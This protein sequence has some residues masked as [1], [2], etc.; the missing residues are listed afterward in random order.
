MFSNIEQQRAY[1]HS[2]R[3]SETNKDMQKGSDRYIDGIVNK[4]IQDK[5]DEI[6]REKK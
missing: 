2:V 3:W 1:K 5:N 6:E 4:A